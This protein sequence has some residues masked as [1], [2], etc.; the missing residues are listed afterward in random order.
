MV[1]NSTSFD[2]VNDAYYFAGVGR[3][4]TRVLKT[5][6]VYLSEAVKWTRARPLLR[7]CGSSCDICMRQ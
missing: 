3:T 6:L 5:D 4:G 1:G 7:M 2:C